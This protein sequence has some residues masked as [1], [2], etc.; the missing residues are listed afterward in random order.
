METLIYIKEYRVPEMDNYMDKN[1]RHLK[2]LFIPHY[3]WYQ[4]EKAQ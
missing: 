1:K 3:E 4:S 2:L